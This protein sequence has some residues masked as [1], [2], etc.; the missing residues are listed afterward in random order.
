M[1]VFFDTET[2]GLPDYGLPLT[3]PAQPKI[4]SAAFILT[5]KDGR[6]MAVFKG[7]TKPNGWTVDEGGKAYEVNK[8]GNEALT[9][10]GMDFTIALRMFRMFQDRA[11]LKVAH[12]YR[13]DGFLMK[14]AH[15]VLGVDAGPDIEK[16][17]TMKAMTD[18]MKLPPTPNMVAA[19]FNDK[20][21][22][23]KLS[24]AYKYCTGKELE[25][26]HDALADVR[27][28]K[29]VFF[30]LLK[31][32]LYVPQPRVTAEQAAAKKAARA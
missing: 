6:E 16:F 29:D 11:V 15:Q 24:E 27:A 21:K 2:T 1:Y 14:A 30:W 31:N 7:P 3:D 20:P 22:S 19:G 18:I 28:C 4:V 25:N 13:F 26:A 5:D 10:Y 32:E 23:A 9:Q 8:L 17:C 12:N